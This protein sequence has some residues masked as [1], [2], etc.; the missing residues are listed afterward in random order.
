[1]RAT[2]PTVQVF[3]R[4]TQAPQ[5]GRSLSVGIGQAGQ[6]LANAA[7][8]DGRVFVAR[9]PEQLLRHM[10]S[11][12]LATRSQTLMNGVVGTEI[13]FSAAASRWIVPFFH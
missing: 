1:M 8:V 7:R 11:V 12:G 10:E 5:I 4:L 9:I 2:G 3:T 13:E 6:T